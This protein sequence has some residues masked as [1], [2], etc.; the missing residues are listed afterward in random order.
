MTQPL[1]ES[2]LTG[3]RSAIRSYTLRTRRS[4]TADQVELFTR[5]TDVPCK[6]SYELGRCL[7]ASIDSKSPVIS[8]E[9]QLLRDQM[10]KIGT[11]KEKLESDFRMIVSAARGTPYSDQFGEAHQPLN[12]Q[13]VLAGLEQTELVKANLE[14]LSEV[15][16]ELQGKP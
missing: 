15:Y 16:R 5:L 9:L 7:L 10:E 12:R 14:K 8:N 4:L 1:S 13:K 11:R 6:Y 2:D 3:L